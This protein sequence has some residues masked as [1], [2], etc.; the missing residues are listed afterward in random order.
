MAEAG[1]EPLSSFCGRNREPLA[2]LI[3]PVSSLRLRVMR[4]E[5]QDDVN[6]A[7]LVILVGGNGGDR[8]HIKSP[9]LLPP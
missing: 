9:P 5:P 6:F 8:E 3:L 7:R 2:D 1:L 4:Q